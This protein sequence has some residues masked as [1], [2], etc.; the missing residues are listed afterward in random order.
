MRWARSAAVTL[1][2][3]VQITAAATV[4]WTI[5][6]ALGDHPD[7]FFA[8]IAAI[9]ALSSPRGERGRNAVRLLLGVLIG[10]VAGE[11]TLWALGSGFGRLAVA[12]FAAT[13]AAKTLGGSRLVIVQAAGGAVLTVASA[14]GDAGF[15][16]LLDALIG[17]GVALLGSQLLFSP[18]PVALVRRAETNAL[19][20]MARALDLTAD[21]LG[22]EDADPSARSLEELRTL[23]D[24]LAELARLRTAG[25][26]VA[27]H[28]VVWRYRRSP[29]VE[30]TENAGH[31]DLLGV[32]CLTLVRTALAVEGD[33]R[34]QVVPYARG[35][36]DVLR[37]VGGDPGD[38]PTRQ[39]AADR[40]LRLAAEVAPLASGG[41]PS[42]SAVAMALRLALGD[43]VVFAGA[44][45]D[46]ARRALE[47]G[48]GVVEVRPPPSTP[49]F[50]LPRPRRPAG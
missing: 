6:G 1:W 39:D 16:R 12:T 28:S 31:L 10:I 9:V 24:D 50:R 33:E 43:L 30:E 15:H 7:P 22:T 3:L 25:P 5:A 47:D 48:S 13:V 38:R 4:A 23:R 8:P 27:R 14:G 26:H 19:R 20:T 11:L 41:S 46:D 37:S 42:L 44:P 40:A 17:A 18:E 32:S 36:A 34:A 45:V 2:P 21:A 35:L 49:R 29:V